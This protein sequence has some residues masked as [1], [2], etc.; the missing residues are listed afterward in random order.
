[1]LAG[2]HGYR[3][4]P[5]NRVSPRARRWE[6]SPRRALF[7]GLGSRLWQSGSG[8][9]GQGIRRSTVSAGLR[10]PSLLLGVAAPMI[11]PSVVDEIRRL[12]AEGKYSQRRIARIAG[13]SRG[14]V[15]A[16]A[17]GKRRDY[18]TRARDLEPEGPTGPPRRCPGCGG[19]VYLP[20]R[21]CHVRKLVG[22]AR[23]ARPPSRGE[24]SLELDLSG[25]HRARYER[26]RL[27]RTGTAPRR[28]GR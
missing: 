24:T 25:D 10:T 27:R 7:V 8:N 28:G 14:T 1:M 2:I 11:A 15:G 12:L 6:S 21:L 9:A 17:S 16:I 22:E 19:L 23:I 3:Q 18:A 5:T 4:S 20:C 26:V 13:V